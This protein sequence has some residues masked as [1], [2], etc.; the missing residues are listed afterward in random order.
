MFQPKE[1]KGSIPK[2]TCT[3]SVKGAFS[4]GTYI[5][6]NNTPFLIG[7]VITK[8]DNSY[9]IEIVRNPDNIE[10][11]QLK[12]LIKEMRDWYFHCFIETKQQA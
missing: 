3:E 12:A 2:F 6:H 4:Q 11:E 8:E 5:H 7:R 10:G 1:P 9:W